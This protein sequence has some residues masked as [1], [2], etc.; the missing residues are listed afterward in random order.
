MLKKKTHIGFIVL[1]LA[2]AMFI[3]SPAQAVDFAISG[4]I[5]R[6]VL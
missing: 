1:A 3:I 4:Q 6:A 5:N 2:A